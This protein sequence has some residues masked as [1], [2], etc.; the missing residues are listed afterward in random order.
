VT[1]LRRLLGRTEVPAGFTG[2][3]DADERVLA[4]AVTGDGGPVLVTPLG[5][6][7]SGPDGSARRIGWHMISKVT[8]RQGTIT[9]VEAA[10]TGAVDG[11]VLIVDRPPLRLK[12]TEPGRVPE[13]VQA[14]V[15][16]SIRSRQRCELPGGGA[17][18]VRR[19]VPGRDGVLLQLRPDTGTDDAAVRE[20]AASAVD[21]RS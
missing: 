17:W 3:L 12:L 1:L 16:G 10:E 14:R 18:I 9:V 2:T 5:L 20:L 15:E 8:W 11:V 21:Q 6:W 13:L 7:V 4:A 19:K